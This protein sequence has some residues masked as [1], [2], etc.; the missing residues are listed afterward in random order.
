MQEYQP[1][2]IQSRSIAGK[3]KLTYHEEKHVQTLVV[4]LPQD[5]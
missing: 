4:N 5:K 3:K 2:T 1:T